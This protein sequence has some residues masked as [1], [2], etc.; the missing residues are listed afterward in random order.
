MDVRPGGAALTEC[1]EQLAA[2]NLLLFLDQHF[3]QVQDTTAGA[4]FRVSYVDY[5]TIA[6]LA[7][8]SIPAKTTD[9]VGGGI[10]AVYR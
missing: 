3:L 2:Q 6:H 7:E 10:Q 8:R 9:A 5:Q 1:S 4:G